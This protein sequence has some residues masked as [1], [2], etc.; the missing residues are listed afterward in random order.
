MGRIMA[1]YWQQRIENEMYQF[2]EAGYR[3]HLYCSVQ[4]SFDTSMH[5]VTV[6]ILGWSD[7]FDRIFNDIYD[8]M[9]EEL[10]DEGAY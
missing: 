5:G 3:M 2:E 8:R 9:K 10:T 7:G 6:S 1:A 4:F